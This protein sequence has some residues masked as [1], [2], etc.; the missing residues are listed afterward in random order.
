MHLQRLHAL[1]AC[2]SYKWDVSAS[3][4]SVLIFCLDLLFGDSWKVGENLVHKK[5]PME[6]P[7]FPGGA[8]GKEPA[9]QCRRLKTHGF[10]P[11]VGKIPW[12]RK[13]QPTAVFLLEN[14]MDRGAWQPT[15]HRIA[16]SR[17]WLQR[18]SA[19]RDVSTHEW[20]RV[21]GWIY[22]RRGCS[23]LLNLEGERSEFYR[24]GWTNRRKHQRTLK[25][26]L[27]QSENGKSLKLQSK[28]TDV[29]KWGTKELPWKCGL[30]RGSGRRE[31]RKELQLLTSDSD[32]V[33]HEEA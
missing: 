30:W 31:D 15:V 2:P 10:D 7:G 26:D 24:K 25:L 20:G 1:G 14:P 21:A 27:S 3:L 23:G 29:S 19:A 5:Q 17:T 33:V 22:T 12:R 8:S 18:L 9:C 4:V 11:W 16:K 13:W 28:E 6:A 32:E